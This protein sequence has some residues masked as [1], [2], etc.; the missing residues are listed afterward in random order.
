MYYL[1]F[2]PKHQRNIFKDSSRLDIK[3]CV[4]SQTCDDQLDKADERILE[5]P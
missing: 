2:P 1:Y 3:T 4:I 5:H